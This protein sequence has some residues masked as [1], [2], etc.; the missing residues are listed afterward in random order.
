MTDDDT[1][2]TTEQVPFDVTARPERPPTHRVGLHLRVVG[3]VWPRCSRAVEDPRQ[4]RAGRG[5]R[6][7]GRPTA[8][9][10]SGDP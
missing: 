1:A 9:R 7:P 5:N 4:R 10:A 3:R 8:E 2:L 6:P